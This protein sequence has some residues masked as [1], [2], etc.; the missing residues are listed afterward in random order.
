MPGREAAGKQRVAT[1]RGTSRGLRSMV[2]MDWTV[3]LFYIQDK[4]KSYQLA[5]NIMG[6]SISI[7]HTSTILIV[8]KGV[9]TWAR[10]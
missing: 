1:S 10:D 3:L 7:M 9:I 2:G 8:K 5:A 4:S 6:I